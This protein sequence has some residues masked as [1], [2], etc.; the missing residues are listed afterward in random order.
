MKEERRDN[1]GVMA[2][3]CVHIHTYL[4]IPSAST[5]ETAEPSP[6]THVFS[7]QLDPRLTGDGV[8]FAERL[9]KVVRYFCVSQTSPCPSPTGTAHTQMPPAPPSCSALPD[10]A[11]WKEMAPTNIGT[12]N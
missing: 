10:S 2:Y 4:S 12:V 6:Q 1:H 3:M 8:T 5:G 9:L 7:V 11:P